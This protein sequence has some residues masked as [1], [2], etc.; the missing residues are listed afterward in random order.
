MKEILKSIYG[1]SYIEPS[2]NY[3]FNKYYYFLDKDYSIFGIEKEKL[4][5]NELKLILSQFDLLG[6][7]F[8]YEENKNLVNF[9]FNRTPIL[10]NV[11]ELKYY[12]I[13]FLDV[14]EQETI[15]QLDEL[16]REL[17]LTNTH[18][19]KLSNIY[20][21]IVTKNKDIEMKNTLQSIESDFLIPIIAFESD[22]YTVNE[23]LPHCFMFDLYGFKMY[24][25]T[26]KLIIDK[27]DL[28]RNCI[29][30]TIDD[31]VRKDFKTY[32]LKNYLNDP[33]MMNIISTYFDTN[34]NLS[35]AAKKCYM[36]RNTLINKIDRFISDTNFNI[37][38]YKEAMLVYLALIM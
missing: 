15:S 26:Q 1:P 24:N 11:K 27:T 33:E 34:F 14:K 22:L 3:D 25:N 38:D 29:L 28:L 30:T 21:I 5:E 19:V 2:N 31:Q 23:Y 36:H 35:L 9:L 17:Y 37:R 32:V 10:D 18:F 13:K 8:G 20:I 6:E 12:F 4:T 16:L 7:D